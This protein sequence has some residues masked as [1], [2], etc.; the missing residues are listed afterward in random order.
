MIKSDSLNV[1]IYVFVS[2][3]PI[4]K[5]RMI[6]QNHTELMKFW[7]TLMKFGKSS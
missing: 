4:I 2:G 1:H 3:W 5:I 7:M 6:A